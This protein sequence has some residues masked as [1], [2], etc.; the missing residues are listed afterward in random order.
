[1]LF[2]VVV[3]EEEEGYESVVFAAKVA[4]S[5]TRTGV[6]GSPERFG[7]APRGCSG[8]SGLSF[9]PKK[10]RS[11]DCDRGLGAGLRLRIRVVPL[12]SGVFEGKKDPMGVRLRLRV[13]KGER[14]PSR[15]RR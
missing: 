7:V 6:G 2:P 15:P 12:R 13:V 9:E 5:F 10:R 8:V 14:E 1:M 3:V 4:G 11:G